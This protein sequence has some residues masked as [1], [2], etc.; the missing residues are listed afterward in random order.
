MQKQLT[1]TEQELK[2]RNYSHKT[3]KSYL[4][5]LKKYFAF[6]KNDFESLDI[7]NIKDFLLFSEKQGVSAQ[8]CNLFPWN[9]W[10]SFFYFIRNVFDAS[11]MISMRRVTESWSW[12]EL[13]KFS[14]ILFSVYFL[15]NSM[16][17]NIY[18]LWMSL[19]L[20]S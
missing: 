10:V 16:H 19:R 4:Y 5:G 15:I 18:I 13:K 1:Q 14:S 6:K 8:A 17:S 3:I 11:P 12:I 9:F 2:I 20:S 7:N